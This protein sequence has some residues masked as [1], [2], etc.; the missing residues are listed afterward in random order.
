[1][2]RPNVVIIAIDSLR[3]SHL[4]CYGYDK[5]TSPNIDALAKESVVFDRAFAPGIPTMPSFTT[6]L[7]GLHPYRHGITAHSSGQRLSECIVPLPQ[8]ARQGGYVTIGIDNLAVQGNG[9][10]SW[11]SRGFDFYSGYLYKP[12]SNQS[13]QIADRALRFIT[14][15]KDKPFL[16]FVH[17]WDPHTPYGPPKP[18]D[19][20]HYHPDKP[21]TSAPSMD[22]IKA[23]SPEYYEAFLGEMNLKVADDYDYVVAQY[24]GEISYV[25]TQVG[26]ILDHLK[27]S[28]LWDNT[29]VVLMSD[30]GEC[31]GEGDVYFDHHGLYDAVLRV[32]LMCHMPGGITTGRSSAIVSTEDILPTLMD[33]CGW[34]GPTEY[35]LTGRSFGAALCANETFLGRDRIFGVES[36]RQASLCLRTE[37]WKYILPITEDARGNPLV[38]IY[39]QPRDPSPLLFDLE[40]DPGE[41]HDV[42]AQF[43]D[44]LTALSQDLADWRTSEVAAR[45]GDDPILEN[46]LSL[47]FDA[48]MSRL[49]A[50]QL[51]KA[52]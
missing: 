41:K 4:G 39:G 49:R 21:D 30:H 17:L 24:D 26:R 51:F 42:S 25:D 13:E 48:F 15:Y 32:A 46:G 6:M 33:L 29:I 10:G 18:F 44:V 27:T 5:P 9:R 28:G 37:K 11:F 40:N 45:G 2:T 22:E 50:R 8:V 35:A 23:I 19:T 20:L 47:G 34:E 38:D 31:F 7:S 16:L 14:D 36:S 3:A 1:M 52:E 43:P 12:F